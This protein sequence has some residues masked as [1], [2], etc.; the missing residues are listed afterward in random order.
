MR[1]FR[2]N[3]GFTLIL[4][5]DMATNRAISLMRSWQPFSSG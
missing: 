1:R 3:I 2:Y 4:C 5:D